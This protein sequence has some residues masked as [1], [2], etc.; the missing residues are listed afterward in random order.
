M[1]PSEDAQKLKLK[2]FDDELRKIKQSGY[3]IENN[4]GLYFTTSLLIF[5][6]V[7]FLMMTNLFYESTYFYRYNPDL[8]DIVGVGYVI[9]DDNTRQTTYYFE[10]DLKFKNKLYQNI[11]S[12][13]K[14][15]QNDVGKINDIIG[16][17]I[18][19]FLINDTIKLNYTFSYVYIF[20][21]CL[22]IFIDILIIYCICKVLR[23]ELKDDKLLNHEKKR[24][25]YLKIIEHVC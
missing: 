13:T 7:A 1:T 22:C 11:L 9:S 6:L 21:F 16:R 2:Q 10:Y 20:M 17:Q 14:H 24:R 18:V 12:D 23:Y 15:Y 25:D 5:L 3:F 19:C 8:C 4:F